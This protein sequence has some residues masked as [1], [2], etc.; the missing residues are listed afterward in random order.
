MAIIVTMPILLFF[1][2]LLCSPPLLAQASISVPEDNEVLFLKTDIELFIDKQGTLSIDEIMHEETA[3]IPTTLPFSG[4]YTKNAH[5]FRFN[6]Q[7]DENSSRDW[8]LNAD[9][10]YLDSVRLYSP[11]SSDDTAYDMVQAGDHTAASTRPIALQYGLNSFQ[12]TLS[13]ELPHTFYLRLQTRSTSVLNLKLATA[14][15]L[16]QF[17]NQDNVIEGLKLGIYLFLALHSLIMWLWLRKSTY[18]LVAGYIL[19]AISLNISINGFVAQS[20]F[21]ESLVLIDAL[22]PIGSGMQIIFLA[23]FFIFFYNT[24]HS[25]PKLHILF[26]FV[27]LFSIV[28]IASIAFD[29]FVILKPYL[30]MTVLLIILCF[31]YVTWR[32]MILKQLGSQVIFWGFMLY[33]L[34][35]Y[36]NILAASGVIPA[37][38]ILLELPQIGSIIFMV[39]IQVGLYHQVTSSKKLQQDTEVRAVI[40]ENKALVEKHRREDQSSFMTMVTHE[41]RTPLAEIDSAIQMLNLSPSVDTSASERHNQIQLSVAHLNNL[42][43]NA[44]IAERSSNELLQPQIE[45]LSLRSFIT[46]LMQRMMS[47]DRVYHIDIPSD[48]KATVSPRLFDIAVSNLVVNALKYSPEASEIY[49]QIVPHTQE[50]HSGILVTVTNSYHSLIKPDV[51]KWFKKY[52]RDANPSNINGFGLGLYLVNKIVTAHNGSVSCNVIPIDNHWQVSVSLWFPT[53][54]PSN[55]T[56][57]L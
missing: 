40:A 54:Y 7:R 46:T 48:F 42:L 4:G 11:S 36:A 15:A 55:D 31:L 37:A 26:V 51:S 16:A 53:L 52:Y 30:L 45:L 28:T 20:L 12:I 43:E 18:L 1:L 2:S 21:P 27:T 22:A 3:F 35:V 50:T 33:T 32:A 24:K 56:G 47:N 13:D 38:P 19:G 44:L 29:Q 41:F 23:L 25:F 14:G 9:P 49:V 8:I 34:M 57:T 10:G 39:F 6:L 17:N 5:W